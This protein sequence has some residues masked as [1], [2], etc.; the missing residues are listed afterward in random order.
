M[1]VY[2]ADQPSTPGSPSQNDGA[3][4]SPFPRFEEEILAYW[5]A[6]D[7]FE[8]TLKERSPRKTYVFYDGPPFATGLPH[9]GHLLQ[10]VLKDA[11][12]R[13]WT[14]KGYR[15]PRRWGWDCHGLPVENLVEK[16]LKIASK[17]EIEAHGI[18]KFNDACRASVFQ[19][20]SEWGKYIDR[21]GRWVD[22][23]DPYMTLQTEYIES[24]WWVF[25]E[26]Y[27]KEL[28]YRGTRV[29]LFCPRCSTSLSN[30]EI[31][32]GNSY[33]DREDPAVFVKFPVVGEEKTF[34]L[35]WTTTPWTLPAN[36]GLAV[37]PD[38]TYVK[39]KIQETGDV[40]FFAE[41]R[42][43]DVL[44]EWGGLEAGVAKVLV[45]GRFKGSELVG[46]KYEPP[47]SFLNP[48]EGAFRVVPGTHVTADDGTG[49]VHTAPAYGEEDLQMGREHGL[50]ILHMVDEEGKMFPVCGKFAGLPMKEADAPITQDLRERGLLYR[51]DVVM[52]SVPVCW[53]CSTLLFY[54][55][56]PAWFVNITT[57]KERMLKT[58]EKINWHPEHFR[59]GRFGKGLQTAP[60]WNVSRTRYWGS[61]IPVWECTSCDHVRVIGSVKELK[62]V[63]TPGT[64]GK[65][66]DLHRPHIDNVTIPCACGGA[67]KRTPEV[68]DCW[69][70]SGSMPVASLHYPFK[71]KKFFEQHSP[72]DFIAEGQDQTR[73]WFYALHVLST[74]LFNRPAFKNVV[75]TG[76]VLA[77]DGKKM[78]KSL[79]NYPD[80]WGVLSK[81]GA[82]ALRYYLLTSPVVEAENLNF[83][84]RDLQTI[85][86]TF[87]N[88]YWNIVVF[89]KTY[90]MEGVKIEK[91]RSVHVMDR[92][93]LSR[94]NRLVEE[95]TQAMDAYGLVKAARPLREF[96]DD[97]STWWL[98]RSR[99]RLKSE[100]EA[101]RRDA[102]RTLYEVLE[103]FTKLA[104]PFIPFLAEKVYQEIGGA[105]TSVHLEAWP[106]AVARVRD[107]VL[108]TDMQWIR[109]AASIAH[110][111]RVKQAIPVRQALASLKITFGDPVLLEHWEG[112]K[113]LLSI[114]RDEV[115]VETVLLEGKTGLTDPWEITLDTV[116]TPELRKKGYRREFARH[117]MNLRKQVG[118]EPKD[119]AHV[120]FSF[121]EGEVR[122]AMTEQQELLAKE[123][124]ALSLEYV[125]DW[126]AHEEPSEEI[127]IGGEKGRIALNVVK[128][129]AE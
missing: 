55:A 62:E 51:A 119:R 10:S 58:A 79:N 36:T 88:L 78:S 89:Y 98:R 102:V 126:S 31:A 64:L 24:V 61:P 29:S 25:S 120:L 96:I 21:I 77:E 52:H 86:R 45:L 48:G 84:E 13:Y 90:A 113:D 121:G 103:T 83:S 107:E 68:F 129:F 18:D 118:L 114:L 76:L 38:M 43:Q 94:L 53:R 2:M 7:V 42:A 73:G 6:Q 108:E 66:V 100:H 5:K 92:W 46:M 32:M 128:E 99:E 39:V 70:E 93:I 11:V 127:E 40:L 67:M 65:V 34:F 16:Q 19:Y 56:Q 33:V 57:L 112:R 30:F 71:Q 17:H 69:F 97:L 124:R 15:V 87:L 49:I 23:K 116:M 117:V 22:F 1:G 20:E 82:D 50:P 60:D 91:P 63:A 101:D 85:T 111:I 41:S 37:H 106:K 44:K 109:Q 26:L 72:A 125:A 47:F 14:M 8:R 95:T 75:V 12:P 9:Y 4:T 35:A 28:A 122:E 80:P 27:K 105:K 59:E 74:A 54:K 115:N 81:Y 123:L 104:A 110:E 3:R